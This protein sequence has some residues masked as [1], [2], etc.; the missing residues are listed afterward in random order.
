MDIVKAT[1]NRYDEVRNFYHSL[2]DGM[3]ESTYNIGWKKDVYPSPEFL[4]NSITDGEL[5][6]GTEDDT[7]I[8]S[9]V[10]N[11]RCND[12]Y[13]KL[14]WQ[15]A[16]AKDEITVIHALG[17]HPDYCG[18]GYAK[19]MV[20]KAFEIADADNQKAIRLDVLKGNLPAKKLYTEM[21]FKHMYTLQMY[22]EDTGLTDYKLYEYV[23][24]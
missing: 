13:K 18:K 22:Y 4:Q 2:I 24:K 3:K 7:I 16:A 10:L 19:E 14:N 1:E 5:Y 6:I 11:H 21:G 15:T 8:A 23:L 20:K 9:M 12:G 17:V